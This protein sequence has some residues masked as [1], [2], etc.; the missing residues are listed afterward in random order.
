MQ[1]P[2][3][4]LAW[5]ADAAARDYA[6]ALNAIDLKPQHLGILTLLASESPMVQARLGDR[7]SIVKPAIVGLVNELE[8]MRLIERRAHP[9]DGRA[10]EIHLLQAGL[11]RVEQAKS[12]SQ[13]AT[14]TFFADLTL[15]EQ[16]AFFKTLSKLVKAHMRRAASNTNEANI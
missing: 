10:F 15:S 4:M 7:L 6:Q 2:G 1:A 16:Q 9:S 14:T 12:V 3:F 13:T 8:D 11:E 5:I